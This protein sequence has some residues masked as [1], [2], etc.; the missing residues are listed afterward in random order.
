ME[1]SENIKTPVI[2]K[3]YFDKDAQFTK[4]EPETQPIK[5]PNP[6]KSYHHF[7]SR[8]FSDSSTPNNY[9]NPLDQPLPSYSG[10]PSSFR[11]L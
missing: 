5:I 10:E 11:F 8:T 6:E 4:G 3:N 7:L 9:D 1:T 2:I